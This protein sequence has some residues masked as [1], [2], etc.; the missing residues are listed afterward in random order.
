MKAVR[1]DY[2]AP[3]VLAY[4][5]K[6]LFSRTKLVGGGS[7]PVA[8]YYHFIFDFEFSDEIVRLIEENLRAFFNAPKS[9]EMMEMIPSNARELL[10]HHGH[11]IRADSASQSA[12]PIVSVIKIE[13]FYDLVGEEF[14]CQVPF[15]VAKIVGWEVVSE[16]KNRPVVRITAVGAED[17]SALKEKI[18]AYRHAHKYSH[19]LLGKKLH[20][21]SIEED[22]VYWSDQGEKIKTILRDTWYRELKYFNV[23]LI[24]TPGFD[25]LQE[26][27]DRYQALHKKKHRLAEWGLVDRGEADGE[28]LFA[29]P[30]GFCDCLRFE[31]S[32]KVLEEDLKN[33]LCFINSLWER[34][35]LVQEP[36][37]D[38]S[39]SAL[40]E[41]PEG[42][43]LRVL[44]VYGRAHPLSFLSV[45]AVGPHTFQLDVSVFCDL[46]AFVALVIEKNE[47]EIPYFLNP[48][49]IEIGFLK[50]DFESAAIEFKNECEKLGLRVRFYRE[51]F[52]TKSEAIQRAQIS[53]APHFI[54]LIDAKSVLYRSLGKKKL[55]TT[56]LEKIANLFLI[57]A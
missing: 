38:V 32:Q 16:W 44:D 19:E 14:I 49:Q 22:G 51:A 13:E 45:S 10:K 46:E 40:M 39:L 52:G 4:I 3:Q 17:Q 34:S 11:F 55:E 57:S 36:L 23:D 30:Q 2:I 5:V 50:K 28:G 37:S 6:S 26:R 54:A 27:F 35:G 42:I 29:L 21:F 18:K 25:P 33:C 1:K 56:S 8:F 31:G 9:I 53:H 24:A 47:G 48:V 41:S 7:N 20:F 43:Y 15:Q 12:L